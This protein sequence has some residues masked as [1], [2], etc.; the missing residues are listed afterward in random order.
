MSER[1]PAQSSCRL[2]I[3][4]A[5]ENYKLYTDKDAQKQ[6]FK[7]MVPSMR[8]VEELFRAK[9]IPYLLDYTPS[10]CHLLF[11]NIMETRASEELRKIGF[12]EGDLIKACNY[13]DPHDIRRWYGI[14]LD[15]AHVFNGLG[16]LAEYIGLLAM[17]RFQGN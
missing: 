6:L 14:S 8:F 2:K 13:I 17:K 9:G 12:V 15:A 11:Q 4:L 10:G 5:A 7:Q 16:K 1:G 3:F